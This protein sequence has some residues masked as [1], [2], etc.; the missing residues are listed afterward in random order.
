MEIIFC[1]P[2]ILTNL[3]CLSV[4]D[5]VYHNIANWI[6]PSLLVDLFFRQMT[7]AS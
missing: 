3:P 2:G 5:T 6:F 7:F 4:N 1:N